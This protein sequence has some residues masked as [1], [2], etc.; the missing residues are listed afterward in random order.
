MDRPVYRV[1]PRSVDKYIRLLTALTVVLIGADLGGY[2]DR[3]GVIPTSVIGPLQGSEYV[4]PNITGIIAPSWSVALFYPS[5]G[6]SVNDPYTSGL[7]LFED[8]RPIGPPH[9]A[10]QGIAEHGGGRYSHWIDHLRFSSSDNSDPR[11]NDRLYTVAEGP[12]IWRLLLIPGLLLVPLV[13]WR[14]HRGLAQ[15][16]PEINLAVGLFRS[17]A[18]WFA[19]TGTLAAYIVSYYIVG[20]PPVPIIN[21]D[22]PNYW[23]A[24]EIV[25]V[26]YPIFLWTVYGLFGSLKAV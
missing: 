21:S 5:Q 17:D 2:F 4:V 23:L 7:R 16:L 19:V 13:A 3:S 1:A 15:G 20:A 22:S 11:I 24:A 14:Q 8:G 18:T 10:H 9:S 12:A 25:P 26:G 6:D